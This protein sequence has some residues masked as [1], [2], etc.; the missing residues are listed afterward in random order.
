[1]GGASASGDQR[2]STGFFPELASNLDR[3]D[4]HIVPPRRF[5]AAVVDLTVMFAAE[6][7]RKF[8]ADLSAECAH[9]G[10]TEMMRIGRTRAAK[11]AGLCADMAEV[12]LVANA[13]RLAKRK[14]ALVDPVEAATDA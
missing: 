13:S 4:P 8:V 1:M 9:L 7:N 6:R 12:G 10:E 14:R 3:V 5:V 2:Q 11:K